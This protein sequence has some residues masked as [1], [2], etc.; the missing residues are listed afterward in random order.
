[1]LLDLPDD[2]GDPDSADPLTC[3]TAALFVQFS[4]SFRSLA[5]TPGFPL[6]ECAPV[7]SGWRSFVVSHKLAA[8][9]ALRKD[10]RED[11]VAE[12]QEEYTYMTQAQFEAAFERLGLR[13]LASIPMTNPWI[14]ERRWRGKLALRSAATH[15]ALDYPATNY[16]IAGE[17]VSLSEGVRFAP[18]ARQHLQQPSFL[19]VSRY[20]RVDGAS[21]VAGGGDRDVVRRPYGT[22]DCLPFF[23]GEGGSVYVLTRRS[24]PRPLLS[25]RSALLDGSRAPH[26]LTEPLSMIQ[27][28]SPSGKSGTTFPV[29]SQHRAK[30][31]ASALRQCCENAQASP[32]ARSKRF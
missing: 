3:S 16:V 30:R 4:K 29:T 12:V 32:P 6:V 5:P 9:F 19:V 24:Y 31:L 7:K 2:A 15:E 14:V 18:V 1:V 10:Y 8:E 27:Q 26:Y 11:W 20:R 17:R 28:V 13:I 25:A 23:F 22:L 21:S